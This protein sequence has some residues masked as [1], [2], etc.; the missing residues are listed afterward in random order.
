[1]KQ[2]TS[3]YGTQMSVLTGLLLLLVVGYNLKA[4]GSDLQLPKPSH[5]WEQKPLNGDAI[6][7]Y[8]LKSSIKFLYTI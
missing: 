6:L 7:G 8:K 5:Q 1:M 3:K 2:C 4:C